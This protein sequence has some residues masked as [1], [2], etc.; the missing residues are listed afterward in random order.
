[1]GRPGELLCKGVYVDIIFSV[2]FKFLLS[3][4]LLSVFV[5]HI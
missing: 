5:K 3:P 4:Y 1:M 2:F